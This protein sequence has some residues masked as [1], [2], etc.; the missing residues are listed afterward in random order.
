MAK[1]FT[2]GLVGKPEI[3][4]VLNDWDAAVNDVMSESF[5]AEILY[6]IRN[7]QDAKP[8][9]LVQ[10][11]IQEMAKPLNAARQ[12]VQPDAPSI[13]PFL[14]DAFLT[15][16]RNV[17]DRVKHDLNAQDNTVYFLGKSKELSYGVR[18]DALDLCELVTGTKYHERE[19]S[20]AERWLRILGQDLSFI[21]KNAAVSWF[22]NLN[23]AANLISSNL[24]DAT[25]G[26]IGKKR[27]QALGLDQDEQY[28]AP[29]GNWN[30]G[31]YPVQLCG[32]IALESDGVIKKAKVLAAK[33]PNAPWH[34]YVEQC[35]RCCKEMHNP[36]VFKNDAA[37]AAQTN[38]MLTLLC[39][40]V[41]RDEP[42][43]TTKLM[44]QTCEDVLDAVHH[45]TANMRVR[46]EAVEAAAATLREDLTA[47][48]N[49]E[50]C[51]GPKP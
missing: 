28:S 17:L 13:E 42:D 49:E 10:Q 4:K 30:S 19:Y 43:L 35:T 44:A 5:L 36:P 29:R 6:E 26:D 9:E 21:R 32:L 24:G 47:R 7:A 16:L 48:F 23:V 40:V 1:N 22:E 27:E 2:K 34:E 3:A 37:T 25:R 39:R 41:D 51:G 46:I 18:N 15:Q 31:M 33:I 12:K 20:D 45:L 8:L 14:G 11:K 50:E 38:E